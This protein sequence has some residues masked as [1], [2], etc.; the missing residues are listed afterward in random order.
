MIINIIEIKAMFDLTTSRIGVDLFLEYLTKYEA[1]SIDDYLNE[2]E[3]EHFL[4][5]LNEAKHYIKSI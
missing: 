4:E 2:A 3:A 1:I 5:V